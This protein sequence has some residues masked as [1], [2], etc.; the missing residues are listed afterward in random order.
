MG[1]T[2]D[3]FGQINLDRPLTEEQRNYLLKFSST[4]RIKRDSVMA[5]FLPDPVRKSVSLPIG[6]EGQYFVGGNGFAGQDHDNSIVDYNNPP[7]HQ[8]GLWCHWIPNDDGTA[9]EWD[10]GEKFYEYDK[11][12]QYLI[13]NFLSR[14]GYILNGQIEWEGESRTDRGMIVVKDNKVTTKQGQMVYN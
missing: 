1:Y 8:P 2:T 6:D 4:R 3:F 5:Q 14:W 9:I 7:N 11:W 10:G 12:M 13:D